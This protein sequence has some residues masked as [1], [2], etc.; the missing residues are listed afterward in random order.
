M[1]SLSWVFFKRDALE[2][3]SW[4]RWPNCQKETGSLF[5]IVIQTHI[6]KH[7][8]SRKPSF[9][10]KPVKHGRREKPQ[11]YTPNWLGACHLGLPGLWMENSC[12]L[13]G[14]SW[15]TDAFHPHCPLQNPCEMVD[16]TGG[17]WWLHL[18]LSN[19]LFLFTLV[20]YGFLWGEVF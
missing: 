6:T 11:K 4:K 7:G 8:L 3:W 12:R 10:L 15:A 19:F 2:P 20:L 14:G 18:S 9:Q 17:S 13:K 5:L 16:L 1:R